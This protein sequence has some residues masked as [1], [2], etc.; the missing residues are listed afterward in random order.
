M[1]SPGDVLLEVDK[2][3]QT[4]HSVKL[5]APKPQSAASSGTTTVKRVN[6]SNMPSIKTS[7]P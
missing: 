6:S 3:H 2:L 4:W 5:T 7:W 1:Q